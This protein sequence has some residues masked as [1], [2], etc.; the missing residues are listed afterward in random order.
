MKPIMK[1]AAIMFLQSVVPYKE[2]GHSRQYFATCALVVEQKDP[3]TLRFFYAYFL[4]LGYMV[5]LYLAFYFLPLSPLARAVLLD[6]T[7]ILNIH[8]QFCFFIIGLLCFSGYLYWAMYFRSIT[9]LGVL[10]EHAFFGCAQ[11]TTARSDAYYIVIVAFGLVDGLMLLIIAGLI[12]E[13]LVGT[14]GTHLYAAF[15]SNF[16]HKSGALLLQFSARSSVITNKRCLPI[17]L[18]LTVWTHINRL[19]VDKRYGI[20]YGALD[21]LVTRT[22]FLKCLFLYMECLMYAYTWVKS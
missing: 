9:K 16:I 18:Q 13:A 6:T 21:I 11:L 14:L 2:L 4:F 5:L 10:A 12:V 1:K 22:S 20:N 15:I 19:V 8:P 3:G 17:R 7:F